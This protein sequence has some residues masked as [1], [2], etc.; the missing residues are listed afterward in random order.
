MQPLI[1]FGVFRQAVED[2]FE[3]R[4]TGNLADRI[5][6]VEQRDDGVF[7]VGENSNDLVSLERETFAIMTEDFADRSFANE[8]AIRCDDERFVHGNAVVLPK[9]LICVEGEFVY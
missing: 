8:R 9:E 7:L 1:A 6:S 3:E 4:H 5:P 2:G